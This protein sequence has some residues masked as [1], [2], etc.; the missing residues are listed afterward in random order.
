MDEKP[1]NIF[2]LS[3]ASAQKNDKLYVLVYVSSH[4][5]QTEYLNCPGVQIDLSRCP[6]LHKLTRRFPSFRL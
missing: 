3:W 6:D 2:Y 4:M 5:C 1:L